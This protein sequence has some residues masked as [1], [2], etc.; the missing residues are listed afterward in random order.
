MRIA[1]FAKRVCLLLCGIMALAG[2][3][4]EQTL[5]QSLPLPPGEIIIGPVFRRNGSSVS[6]ITTGSG[7]NLYIGSVPPTQSFVNSATADVVRTAVPTQFVRFYSPVAAAAA[8]NQSTAAGSFIAGSNVVRGL[9]PAQIRDVLALPFVPEMQTIVTVP[10]GTC[11][12]TGVGAPILGNFSGV[13]GPNGY[14]PGPWGHGGPP[15]EYLIGTSANP[16]C[17]NPQRLPLADFTDQQPVGANALWYQPRA[18]GGNAGA[19]ANALDH[20]TPPPLFTDMDSIYNALDL[21]NYGDPTRLRLALA[22]LD[23]E[24]YADVPSVE[25]ATGQMFLHVLRDQT[26]LARGFVGPMLGDGVL[27]PWV[28]GFGSG[29]SLFGDGNTHG[30]SFGGGGIAAGMDYRFGPAL[31]AGV[32]AA[33]AHNGFSTSGIPGS[34]GLDSFAVGSYTGYTL[35]AFYVDAALGYSYNSVGVSRSIDFPGVYRGAFANPV[36]NAFLSRA[37][38]GYHVPVANSTT[39]TPFASFQ[40]I[41]VRQPGFAE[42]GA[43]AINLNVNGI[44]RALALSTIGT[45]LTYDLSL[46]FAV[47]LA[48]SA[49]AGWA[50]DY[51]DVNRS[52]AANFEGTPDAN[53]TVNG[54]RWPRNAAEVGVCLS[55][56]LQPANIFVRYDGMLASGASIHSATAGLVIPF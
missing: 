25:I 13:P 9:T 44:T 7:A 15:Q 33:Y 52:I 5:A 14:P 50:H 51:A 45:E 20:A 55:L 24:V 41:V 11:I 29:G 2:G 8:T 36:A 3:V 40:G 6:S 10:A 1:S 48:L 37:E 28:S 30:I 49:R 54:V 27:R 38:A 35:G 12:I 46:G 32:S 34:G 47:P 23:G 4:T 56:P 53:F 42:G 26:H 22:Q 17:Q 43:G 21:L 31:Q 18:G 19:V 39:A 16:G